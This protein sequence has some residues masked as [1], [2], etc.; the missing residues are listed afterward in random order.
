MASEGRD[1][2]NLLALEAGLLLNLAEIDR[3]I[4]QAHDAHIPEEPATEDE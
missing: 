2:A 1:I 3:Q 4:H